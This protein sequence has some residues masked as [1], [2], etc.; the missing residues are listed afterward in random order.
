MMGHYPPHPGV[1]APGPEEPPKE[2][3]KLGPS[4]PWLEEKPSVATKNP[5]EHAYAM[6]LPKFGVPR[7]MWDLSHLC[8]LSH[9]RPYL[10]PK[11][12]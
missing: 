3:G 5:A 10:N 7:V 11:S 8:L 4:A 12:M 6:L 2:T 1:T 9:P